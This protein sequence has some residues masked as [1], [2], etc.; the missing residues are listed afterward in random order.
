MDQLFSLSQKTSTR[1]IELESVSVETFTNL[2]QY[3]INSIKQEQEH[4]D[5]KDEVLDESLDDYLCAVSTI[6][7]EAARTRSDEEQIMS[8][9]VDLGLSDE[10]SKRLSSAYQRH[11]GSLIKYLEKTGS[12]VGVVS[13]I[14]NIDWRLDYA[15]NSRN[16]SARNPLPPTPQ[17]FVCLTVRDFH[18]HDN[19]NGANSRSG[20]V[21]RE[22]QMMASEEELQD[23][24]A[25]VR[26][27]VKQVDR[28]LNPTSIPM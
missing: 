22:I 26:D 1:L 28:L 3:V 20:Y 14:V 25:K 2:L 19:S 4:V 9:L 17:F 24:L 11:K 6:L 21:L 8:T 16:G 12:T 18:N 7:L 23:L 10:F 13:E 27:A 5:V 15:L